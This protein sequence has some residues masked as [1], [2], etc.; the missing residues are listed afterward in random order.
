MQIN[1][2]SANNAALQE[3]IAEQR[4]YSLVRISLILVE[5]GE[6]NIS[7]LRIPLVSPTHTVERA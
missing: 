5:V 3:A 7:G 1:Y 4:P 2:R 6:Y